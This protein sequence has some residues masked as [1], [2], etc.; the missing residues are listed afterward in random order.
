MF[1]EMCS[2]ENKKAESSD[3]VSSNK[4]VNNHK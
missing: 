3:L 1:A 4:I 2:E